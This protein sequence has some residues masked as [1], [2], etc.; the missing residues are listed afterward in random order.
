MSSEPK[1]AAGRRISAKSQKGTQPQTEARNELPGEGSRPGV[2]RGV[3]HEVPIT[4][5]A[6]P[7]GRFPSV[8]ADLDPTLLFLEG[9]LHLSTDFMGEREGSGVFLRQSRRG[10]RNLRGDDETVGECRTFPARL[11]RGDTEV[12]PKFLLTVSSGWFWAPISPRSDHIGEK[13]TS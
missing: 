4:S 3:K 6:C 11:Q 2:P 13:E 8:S 1:K 7:V 12:S 9:K 5:R 10:H